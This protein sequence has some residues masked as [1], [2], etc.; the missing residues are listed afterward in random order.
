MSNPENDL[1]ETSI[2]QPSIE[3]NCDILQR[4][5]MQSPIGKDEEPSLMIQDDSSENL[6]DSI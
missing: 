4:E 5:M 2:Q 1:S 6:V 3:N